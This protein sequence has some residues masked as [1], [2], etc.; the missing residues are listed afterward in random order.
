MSRGALINL[1]MNA[2]CETNPLGEKYRNIEVPALIFSWEGGWC[3]ALVGTAARW[4]AANVASPN[5]FV[6][7]C[8]ALVGTAA[9]C[10]AALVAFPNSFKP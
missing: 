5:G 1:Y 3:A 2:F 7:W 10:H 4:H 9:S 6:G 8:A